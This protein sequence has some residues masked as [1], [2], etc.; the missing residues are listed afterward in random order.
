MPVCVTKVHER[1]HSILFATPAQQGQHQISEAMSNVFFVHTASH[2][3]LTSLK[4]SLL[5]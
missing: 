3:R 4:A 2:H 5:G 1:R